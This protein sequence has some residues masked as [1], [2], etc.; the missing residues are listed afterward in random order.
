MLMLCS[1]VRLSA[2]VLKLSDMIEP[3]GFRHLKIFEMK[4][5]NFEFPGHRKVKMITL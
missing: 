5:N 3:F 2:Y 1:S 4:F